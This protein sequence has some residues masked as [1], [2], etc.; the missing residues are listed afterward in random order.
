MRGRQPL[1]TVRVQLVV[2]PHGH[3]GSKLPEQ[4]N[5]VVGER[6]VVVDQENHCSA[7]VIAVSSAASLR[8]H[9]SGSACG[10]ESATIPAPACRCATPSSRTIVLIAMHVSSVPSSGSA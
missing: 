6:V 1:C 8:R 10:S 9:S 7:R 5:E 3:L 4:V 2:A